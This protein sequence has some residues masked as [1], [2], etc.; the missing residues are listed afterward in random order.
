MSKFHGTYWI[1]ELLP[2][3][4]GEREEDCSTLYDPEGVGVLQISGYTKD[5]EVTVEDLKDLAQEKIEA[6]VQLSESISGDFKGLTG[7]FDEEGQYWQ[8]WYVS[9]KKTALF[10]T[11]NCEVADREVEMDD[12]KIMVA[13]LVAT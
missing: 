2:D 4:V 13:S 6:G 9:H 12:I 5:S 10:I 1:I 11:Y 3:W 8:Y 7:I